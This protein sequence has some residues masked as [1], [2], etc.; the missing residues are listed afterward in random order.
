MQP[1][2]NQMKYKRQTQAFEEF[3]PKDPSGY[4]KIYTQY[5]NGYDINNPAPC[6]YPGHTNVLHGVDWWRNSH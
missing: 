1:F 6:R 3:Q 4:N 5:L 2:I